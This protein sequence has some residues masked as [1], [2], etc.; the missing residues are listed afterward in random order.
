MITK[1]LFGTTSNG[2]EVYEYT[3]TRGGM[4]AGIL[5]LGCVVHSL[6]VPDK[7]GVPTDVVLGYD[8]VAGYE[9]GTTYFGVFVGRFANRLLASRF[10]IDGKEYRLIPN[11]GKNHLHGTYTTRV[12]NAEVQGEELLLTLTSPDGEEGFP[13]ELDVCVKYSL[14]DKGGLRMEY[15]A[16]TDKPTVVN[17]TN[18]SYFN[19]NGGRGDILSHTL[20]IDAES[21]TE[22]NAETCP[23]GRILPV[24]GTPLDFTAEKP[25]G[26]DINARECHVDTYH[27]YDHNFCI[28][29]DITRPCARLRSP[30]SGI[31]MEVYT[32]QPGVQLYTGNF[33]AEG[34]YHS[35][36]GVVY[37]K[38]SGLCLETQH[39]PCSP[40]FD[41]FPSTLLRTNEKYR[42][43][44]EYRFTWE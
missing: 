25:V 28:S 1:K 9:Y 36:K 8:D 38:H 35:G 44:T 43:I 33:I 14:T 29:G 11:D 42:Q 10:E 19:L 24:K 12:F 32:T 39:Y 6:V 20:R 21:Y 23:T 15:T 18:H 17:F 5:T 27:G 3:L 31:A 34:K 37:E 2:E 40:A 4:S 7:N 16:H 22:G 26:R 30:D 13:G 41:D